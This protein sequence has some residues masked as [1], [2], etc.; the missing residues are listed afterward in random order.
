MSTITKL[1]FQDAKHYLSSP[2]GQRAV[3]S[4]SAGNTASFHSGADYATYGK[5]LPQ[6]A[7]AD[8][9]VTSCGKDSAA[10]AYALYIWVEY[11]DLKVR[12][13]HYHLDSIKVKRGQTVKKGTLLGYT[14]QT[15]RATGIHLHL[16]IK[17]I[18]GTKYIDP[19]QWSK[20]EYPKLLA[21]RTPKYKTG[22]YKVNTALLHVRTDAGTEF[23]IKDFSELTPSARTKIMRLAGRKVDGY[24]K[25]LTFTVFEVKESGKYT[26]G[27]TPSGWVALDYC[28]K[29]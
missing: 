25:G 10:N 8:G 11:P 4:T 21:A 6:Y 12:M 1:I 27:R 22:D 5:K 2:Y 13:L 28:K 20:E 3:L 7:I 24:V 16:G 29:V 18:G 15:G 19:E 17:R 14:G 9:K 26:W 23:R